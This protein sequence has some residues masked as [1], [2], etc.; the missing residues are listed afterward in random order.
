MDGG[1]EG[2]RGGGRK[3]REGER[4]IEIKRNINT[5]VSRPTCEAYEQQRK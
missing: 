2:G 4:E 3:E 1:G 5:I